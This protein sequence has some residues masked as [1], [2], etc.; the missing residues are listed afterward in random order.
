LVIGRRDVDGTNSLKQIQAR[1]QALF[2]E[3]AVTVEWADGPTARD[4]I[5]KFKNGT[6][7]WI[8]AKEMISEGTN[9]PRLRIVVIV[10]DIGNR[11]FYEQLVHR[12][13]RNDA[14]DRP[15]DAIIIQLKLRHL[16]EWGTDLETQARIGWERQK[17]L[18][19]N[20]GD[21][22]GDGAIPKY[23]E[24]IA[25]ELENESVV[26]EGEDFTDVDP[27]GR[28]LHSMIG[29]ETKTS[30][31]QLNKVLRGLGQLGVSFK[32]LSDAPSQDELFSI[33][34][35]FKRHK[36]RALKSI[37]TAAV[38]LGGGEDTFRRVTAECKKAAGIRHRLDDVIRDY[39][40]P[41]ETIKAF[42]QAA[43][44]ALQRSQ[45]QGEL[46]L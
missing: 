28:K 10:R 27:T 43:Y 46:E 22:S 18:R 39:P 26:M 45:N 7:R 1:I 29:N 24:G 38:K 15:Q 5:R 11:T 31:W 19:Q 44:R 6:D 30:R 13:T 23:I 14:D 2:N 41:I 33:E 17:Q 4:T 25:A 37:R 40:K 12:V 34:E 42:E 9:L 35:Q 32:G 36:E 21:G 16:H 20:A 8:V 3:T